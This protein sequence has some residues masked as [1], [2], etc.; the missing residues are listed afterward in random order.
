MSASSSIDCLN[1]MLRYEAGDRAGGA[2]DRARN[3]SGA[4]RGVA[5]QSL[6]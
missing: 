4:S 2:T 5:L 6:V 3:R 1:A